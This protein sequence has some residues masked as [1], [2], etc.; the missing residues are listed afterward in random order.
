VRITT[1][2]RESEYVG[3]LD[4]VGADG[5]FHLTL[6]SGESVA[7]PGRQIITASFPASE[8]SQGPA[9]LDLVGGD[10]VFGTIS[11]EDEIG[12]ALTGRTVPRITVPLERVRVLQ[13]PAALKG[14]KEIPHLVASSGKDVVFR[15]LKNSVDRVLGT[16]DLI[17]PKGVTLES[18]L[19]TL[20]FSLSDLVA[21]A[22]SAPDES[23]PVQGLHAVV[24]GADGTRITGILRGTEG[25]CLKMD[26]QHGFPVLLALNHIK[27][28]YFKGGDFVF[29]SDLKPVKVVERPYIDGMVWRYRAD[30]TP[31][32]NPLHLDNIEYPKGLGVHAYCA[33][34]Y[35]LN[36]KYSRFQSWIGIDDEVKTLNAHGAVEFKVLVDG[37]E[38]YRSPLIR[39]LE[40]PR[41]IHGVDLKGA[42]TLTLVVDFGDRNHCGD[43]ADWAMAVLVKTD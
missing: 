28:L 11:G 16:V 36:G 17:G 32:G 2:N 8:A 23:R 5:T 29:L 35:D 42:R 19:G 10:I 4:S 43:R 12:V 25:N 33:L 26:T 22:F 13:F 39:G 31:L 38:S 21:V 14:L 18:S 20:P 34:T 41:R 37:R 9:R 1:V 27:T 7:L 3:K 6:G 40:S 30:R 15:R 24:M